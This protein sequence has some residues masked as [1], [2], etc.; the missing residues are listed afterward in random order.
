MDAGARKLG[1]DPA[2]IRRRNLLQAGDMPHETISK[3][4]FDSGACAD[5][6]ET[7][8]KAAD[9]NGVATRRAEAEARG[10]LH[11]V[12]VAYY[13]E[14]T[15]GGPV[16][17]ARIRIRSNKRVEAWIGTQSTGQGH[18][19]AWAQIIGEKLGISAD[20]IDFPPGDSDLL[21]TGGGTGGSR[22]I[23]MGHQVFFK[24]ADD[25]IEKGRRA[26]SEA[27]EASVEDIE[28]TPEDGGRFRVAGTDRTIDLFEA[29][30][31]AE[32][33]S[34]A[35]ELL[36][37]GDVNVRSNTFPNGAHVVEAEVDPE[38]G[39]AELTRYTIVDD[40][41]R[42]LNPLMVTGQVHGGVAQG[43]GQALLEQMIF[44]PETAQP[45]TGSLMDYTVTRA[46]DMPMLHSSLDE[47]APTPTNPLGVKGC[48]EAGTVGSIP[49]A[50]AAVLNALASAGVDADS[51]QTPLT[52]SRIW[53]ALQAARGKA[54]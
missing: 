19:T 8:L 25:V 14:R 41:G 15:G 35:P 13:M 5:M 42:I 3:V 10:R 53:D 34:G 29:A 24:A 32:T 27:L 22:S 36:G 21:P 4:T 11:G 28:F 1:L 43:V 47:R 54:A 7:A 2:E 16:E 26:A 6:L 31:A 52:P 20:A 17:N 45:L 39:A 33:L 37:E 40:F 51:L 46:D 50:A 18:E 9:Y 12:G 23:I 44:D 48:G 38:T 30:A 49:A